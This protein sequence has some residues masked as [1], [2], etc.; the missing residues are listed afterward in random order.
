MVNGA[1]VVRFDGRKLDIIAL[2]REID[3]LPMFVEHKWIL[4]QDFR[5]P[6]KKSSASD[7]RSEGQPDGDKEMLAA[8]SRVGEHVTV[9]LVSETGDKRTRLAK[10]IESR[11]GYME[12]PGF[13]EYETARL[14][15]WAAARLQSFGKRIS[16]PL[17]MELVDA[18][19][20]DLATLAS[21][22][23]KLSVSMGDAA[24][25]TDDH[26]HVLAGNPVALR[27]LIDEGIMK[28]KPQRAEELLQQTLA[29]NEH[30]IRIVN[31]LI[32][33]VRDLLRARLFPEGRRDAQ[34]AAALFGAMHPFRLRSLYEESDRFSA[35][36]LR[37]AIHS[38]VLADTCLKSSVDSRHVMSLLVAALTG[39]IPH[40]S[41]ARAVEAYIEPWD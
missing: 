28:R 1:E 34:K 41:F 15:E 22:V 32:P 26:M 7:E 27:R 13:R 10:L 11:G 8:L 40:E 17:A 16:P 24:V 12:L 33:R 23:E 6:S 3:T 39:A 5:P 31:F 9:I 20:S 21:E 36:E 37:G 18:V 29:A 14:A 30:P 19:G 2:A 4:V 35:L 25:V 38:L